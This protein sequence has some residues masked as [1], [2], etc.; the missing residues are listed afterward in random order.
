MTKSRALLFESNNFTVNMTVDIIINHV[1]SEVTGSD[2]LR[3]GRLWFVAYT[4]L[5]R[6]E[7][8]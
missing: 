4:I 6:L 1:Q 3:K 8:Q 2:R 7:Y 5:S